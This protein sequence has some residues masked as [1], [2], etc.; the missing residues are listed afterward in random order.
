MADQNAPNDASRK[1]KAEG[2]RWTV[3]VGEVG[4]HRRDHAGGDL[5]A[6]RS[7]EIDDG[8]LAS[9]AEVAAR[10]RGELAANGYHVEWRMH[11]ARA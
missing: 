6:R 5:T 2:D 7:V 8:G 4:A 1:D 11:R 9:V 10:E 3:V